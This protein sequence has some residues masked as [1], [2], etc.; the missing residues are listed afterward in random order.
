M[1]SPLYNIYKTYDQNFD[2]GPLGLKKLKKPIFK[3]TKPKYSF[4]GFPVNLPFGIPAGPL[5]N[6]KFIKGAFDFGF[7]VATYKTV[8]SDIF[9][10]HPYPNILYV[11]SPDELHPQVNPRLNTNMYSPENISKISITNSFG[12]PSKK[13]KI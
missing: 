3:S 8:R 2:L 7:S 13:V 1:N 5:L 6:S 11:D 4:L 9:P 10:C 12:V